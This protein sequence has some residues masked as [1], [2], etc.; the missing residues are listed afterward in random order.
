VRSEANTRLARRV[1]DPLRAKG[2]FSIRPTPLTTLLRSQHSGSRV[3][4]FNSD[5]YALNPLTY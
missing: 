4:Y 1:F 3:A 5:A 2:E